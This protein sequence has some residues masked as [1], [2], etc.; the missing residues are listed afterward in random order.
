M[1]EEATEEEDVV[2]DAVA[3]EEVVGEVHEIDVARSLSDR[4]RLCYS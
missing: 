2:V 3:E 4:I 1:V